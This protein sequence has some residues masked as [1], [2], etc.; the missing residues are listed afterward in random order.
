MNGDFNDIRLTKERKSKVTTDL[1]GDYTHF[2][3]L[4]D[5]NFLVGLPL[6][7]RRSM[8]YQGMVFL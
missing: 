6:Y 3:Q 7:G 5:A 1:V 4:I 2:N 8:W